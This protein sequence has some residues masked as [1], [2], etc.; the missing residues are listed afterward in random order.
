MLNLRHILFFNDW[1]LNGVFT[2]KPNTC[3]EMRC[4]NF[5]SHGALWRGVNWVWIA[6][7]RKV[8]Y[9]MLNI[10]GIVQLRLLLFGLRQKYIESY[11]KSLVSTWPHPPLLN[12]WKQD[13]TEDKEASQ[14]THLQP[15]T[16][17]S[18]PVLRRCC[19]L[20]KPLINIVQWLWC[21]SES[22]VSASW[23]RSVF[24]FH[25]TQFLSELF[26]FL[27]VYGLFDVLMAPYEWMLPSACM[28]GCK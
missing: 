1:P 19:W 26:C 25:C 2:R 8:K 14:R 24:L 12:S 22:W 16:H 20:E 6:F 5:R 17:I 28:Q 3:A 11:N 7:N 10:T 23:G 9:T 15:E 21:V 27:T 18:A 13:W 4:V